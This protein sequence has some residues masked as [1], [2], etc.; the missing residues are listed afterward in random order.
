[1]IRRMTASFL[2][3]GVLIASM[4][5]LSAAQGLILKKGD[6]VAITGDS[7]TEQ[8]RYSK[9]METYLLA[10]VP[11]LDLKVIQLGWSG[12]R[13]P[14]F[15]RR[16]ANDLLF[17]KPDVVTT[18]YGMN[19]GRYRKYEDAIGETYSEA[20]QSIVSALKVAGADAIIGSPGPVDS[21]S[22]DT[23]R[24]GAPA[25]AAVYNE[26]LATLAGIAKRI[27][28]AHGVV[29]ADVNTVMTEAMHKAK[30]EHGVEYHVAGRDG[31]HP[32]DNGHLVMAYTFLKA[33]GLDGKIGTIA[34]D[35]KSETTGSDGH[36]IVS[37][38]KGVVKIESSRYPFCF[39]GESDDPDGTISILSAVPFQQD[40]NR[41]VLSVSNL[42]TSKATVRWGTQEKSFTQEQLAE[43]IN[44]AAEFL[45]N[46]FV[47]AFTAVLEAVA[48]KQR[49]ET[50]MIKHTINRFPSLRGNFEDDAEVQ[51]A[52]DLL[53]KKL[54]QRQQALHADARASVKPVHHTIEIIP[55][56]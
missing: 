16:V 13:A 42:P 44:L 45:E 3:L 43:G 17:W 33:M 20:T 1:M 56:G 14:G 36:T 10:S 50:F 19:D 27:A 51:G 25:P 8:K 24:T 53:L 22:Y 38:N 41:F 7:I 31:V 49:Y 12:E 18:C 35:W 2:L 15:Q 47:P 30:K 32:S 4:P 28:R 40:L 39:Y 11:E 52:V 29:F 26:N 5:V 46:P 34:V 55:E 23:W 21:H 48:E 37:S 54:S 9:F 6:R